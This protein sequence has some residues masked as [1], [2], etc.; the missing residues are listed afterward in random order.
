MGEMGLVGTLC[1]WRY[2]RASAEDLGTVFSSVIVSPAKA[3]V[4]LI[5][6]VSSVD[7]S[8]GIMWPSSISPAERLGN[9]ASDCRPFL[10]WTCP[11]FTVPFSCG[12]EEGFGRAGAVF[13]LAQSASTSTVA[14]SELANGFVS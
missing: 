9:G 14:P 12:G 7:G 6:M 10:D 2:S 8:E 4:R 11:S 3:Y 13:N 5:T 1:D